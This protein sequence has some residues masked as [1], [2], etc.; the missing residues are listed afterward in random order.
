VPR[1][2]AYVVNLRGRRNLL[3]DEEGRAELVDMIRA[4]GGQ[5]LAVDPFGRAYTGRSQNDA[6]EVTPWLVRLDE[7]AE[8]AGVTEVVLT[9]HAGWDG[10]RTRGSW[11]ISGAGHRSSPCWVVRRMTP[12]AGR[13][14]W[15]VAAQ[16][17]S[18]KMT[19]ATGAGA[20]ATGASPARAS[21]YAAPTPA[22]NTACPTS[23]A[24]FS[25]LL[26]S[27]SRC[28]A[29][30][31]AHCAVLMGAGV[32]GSMACGTMRGATCVM[33]S[34]IAAPPASPPTAPASA[35]DLWN[36]TGPPVRRLSRRRRQRR[37]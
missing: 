24:A 13:A 34:V 33:S 20:A 15:K 14:P 17:A 25:S 21:P 22:L 12:R 4:V 5:V 9:A 23:P 27:A 2:R 10:E 32:G 1:E 16:T 36:A 37:Q 31:S 28:P 35:E 19:P 29:V 11:P 6:A 30:R 7:V 3:A 8:Q 18:P 26:D